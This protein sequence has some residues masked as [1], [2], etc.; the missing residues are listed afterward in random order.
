MIGNTVGAG[1]AGFGLDYYRRRAK[2]YFRLKK[3]VMKHGIHPTHI[4][5][6]Q[7]TYCDRQIY[8]AIADSLGFRADYKKICEEYQLSQHQN[9]KVKLVR[10][11]Q[12]P[13]EAITASPQEERQRCNE[14]NR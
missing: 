6:H 12:I 1:M 9:I 4:K 11:D 5:M 13:L 14:E 8:K 3:F 2:K 7:S 10:F